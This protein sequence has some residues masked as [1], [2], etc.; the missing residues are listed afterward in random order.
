MNIGDVVRVKTLDE[1]KN[2]CCK[3]LDD[4]KSFDF[5]KAF[6]LERM[7]KFC[8]TIARITEKDYDEDFDGNV[9]IS[10]ELKSENGEYPDISLYVFT[11]KMLTKVREEGEITEEEEEENTATHNSYYILVGKKLVKLNK[12]QYELV[13]FLKT[14]LTD[15]VILDTTDVTDLT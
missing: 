1:L 3:V 15:V 11:D 14:R 9:T 13:N 2:S 8:G 4:G 5:G 10:Y 7:T 12:S 6:F